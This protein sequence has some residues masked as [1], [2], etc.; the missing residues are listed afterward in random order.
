[1]R[2]VRP[3]LRPCRSAA[4]GDRRHH[5]RLT[6]RR[7]SAGCLLDAH[8]ADRPGDD[9]LL[10]LA[11]ALENRMDL[12]IAVPTLDRVLAR[13]AVAAQD[14]DR[15]LGDAHGD[16]RRFVLAHRTFA[17]LEPAVA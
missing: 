10:D 1:D 16:F 2:G 4:R 7:T 8:A 13:V 9:Q 15:I 14:L 17:V 5:W 6:T 3:P 12:G 11:G